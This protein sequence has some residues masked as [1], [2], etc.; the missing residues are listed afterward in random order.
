[1]CFKAAAKFKNR[2]AKVG[3]NEAATLDDSDLW[4][5]VY[6]VTAMNPAVEKKLTALVQKA[7]ADH[8]DLRPAPA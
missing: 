7:P 1:M 5:T 8:P 2:Y 3:F 6:A 4:P